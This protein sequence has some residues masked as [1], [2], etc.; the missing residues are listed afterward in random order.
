MIRLFVRQPCISFL[1]C[2]FP[3]ESNG[4]NVL[5][6]ENKNTSEPSMKK[7]KSEKLNDILLLAPS[8]Y[9]R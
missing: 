4:G 1:S 2:L 3:I 7:S 5:D 9:D 8:S 6:S